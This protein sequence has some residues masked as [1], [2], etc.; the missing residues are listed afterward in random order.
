MCTSLEAHSSSVFRVFEENRKMKY[1]CFGNGI[2]E[3]ELLVKNG[4]AWTR[5]WRS[6]RG[7]IKLDM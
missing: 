2:D 7:Q 3:P 1:L 6:Y 5:Q 4:K